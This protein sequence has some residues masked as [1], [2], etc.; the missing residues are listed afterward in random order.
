MEGRASL[1]RCSQSG[2]RHK[3]LQR[4][5]VVHRQGPYADFSVW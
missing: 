4:V 5:S 3:L 2:A 1:K